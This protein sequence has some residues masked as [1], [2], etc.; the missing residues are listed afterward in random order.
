M[1]LMLTAMQFSGKEIPGLESIIDKHIQ[2]F[3]DL[4]RRKY[5]SSTSEFKPM[6]LARK[7][8]YF[9]MD[10]VTEI[11]FDHCWGCLSKD[12]DVDKWF[13]SNEKFLPISIMFS[14]IPWL[15]YIF[16][17]PLIGRMVMPSDNDKTG[18]GR[19]LG[20]IKEIVRDRLQVE[21]HEQQK[22]MMGSFFRH[23]ITEQEAVTEAS[24]QIIAGTDTTATAIRT[25]LLYIITN[26]QVLRSLQAEIDTAS[27]PSCIISDEQAKTLPYLQ[28]VIKEGLRICPP[29]SGLFPKK[30]PPEG[31]TI[32]GRFVPGGTDIGVSSW[33]LQR[34]KKV[35]GGDSMLFRPER[36]LEANGERLKAMERS[37]ELGWGYGK[38]QCLGK[39]VAWLE[40]NKVFF[41]VCQTIADRRVGTGEQC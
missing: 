36:W 8:A 17:I 18:P 25:T 3:V 33:A 4:L 6:D 12:E 35:W 28:S 30:T 29:G 26:P 19:L 14:T 32:N 11:S 15:A 10:V 24:L 39:N 27:V 31:D 22:D 13:E 41:E 16:S 23:G 38:Y 20:I 2:S 5:I 9:T 40:L 7:S 37:L 21:G 1:C 34:N